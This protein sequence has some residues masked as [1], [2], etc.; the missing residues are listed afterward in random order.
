M[1]SKPLISLAMDGLVTV[2]NEFFYQLQDNESQQFRKKGL[3]GGSVFRY[4]RT[5]VINL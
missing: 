4:W 2:E 1:Q 5:H 3:N